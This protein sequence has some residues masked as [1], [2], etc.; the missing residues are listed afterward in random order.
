MPEQMEKYTPRVEVS[1]ENLSDKFK[2]NSLDYTKQFCHIYLKRL[3]QS[4]CFLKESID[5]KWGNEFPVIE[6]H[7]L[8]DLDGVK[9]IVMGTLFKDQK[10]KHSILKEL[11][12]ANQLLPQ[13]ILSHFT[14]SSDKLC[15]EDELQR[16][17]LTGNIDHEKLVSG[18]PIALLGMEITQGKFEVSEYIFADLRPQIPR[19]IFNENTFVL[20][21]SGLDLIHLEKSMLH[22]QLLYQLLSGLINLDNDLKSQQICRVIL[23]GKSIRRDI[24]KLK[25]TISITSRITELPD[26]IE[27]VKILD[28]FLFQM[29]Q[30]ID[31]DLMPGEH[32]PSNNTLPQQPMH[33]CMFPKTAAY[34]SFN[35]VTNPYSCDLGGVKILGTSGQPIKDIM[36]YSEILDP[37]EAMESCLRWNHMAPTAPDTLG[38]YPFYD[39]DPF[40]LEECPHVFFAGNQS[41]FDTK[42]VTGSKG[43]QVTLIS[44]PEF[45]S[46]HQ[47]CLLNL[48]NLECSV[49]EI[50]VPIE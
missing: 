26:T 4:T 15:I 24:Q 13:P 16:Y 39:K 27:A 49:L 43:Q 38:C 33:C 11:S 34:K 44:I 14:D 36:G 30:I 35:N 21:F 22:L 17:V 47:V 31:V 32:D 42:V 29:C 18:I 7:K 20:F 19:P 8:T 37:I 9:C 6:L 10:L 5:E 2:I 45:A 40:V 12:E 23:A 28:K 46:T 41:K 25:N 48:K 50:N 1:Y 3:Q